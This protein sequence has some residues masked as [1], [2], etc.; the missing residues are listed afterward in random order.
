VEGA[1]GAKGSEEEDVRGWRDRRMNGPHR[2]AF[3]ERSASAR[4][5]ERARGGGSARGFDS[6]LPG[7]FIVV[8][9]ASEHRARTCPRRRAGSEQ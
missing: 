3:R 1:V 9:V 8:A 7:D 4:R 5:V 2:H 6:Q